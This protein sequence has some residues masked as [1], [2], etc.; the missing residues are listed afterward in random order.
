MQDFPYLCDL[1][2]ESKG[3]GEELEKAFKEILMMFKNAI[4]TRWE[5][6]YAQFPADLR[7]ILTARFG[8]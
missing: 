5:G 8:I 6:Y 4:G 7:N 2:A 3:N 1:F